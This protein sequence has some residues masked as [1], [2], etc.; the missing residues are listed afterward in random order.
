MCAYSTQADAT[1]WTVAVV[2]DRDDIA[3]ETL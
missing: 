3:V 1:Y 2:V